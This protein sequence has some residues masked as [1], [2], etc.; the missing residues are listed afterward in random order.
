MFLLLNDNMHD[1]KVFLDQLDLKIDLS[2]QHDL[3]LEVFPEEK[4]IDLYK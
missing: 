2:H 4:E 1:N 3:V